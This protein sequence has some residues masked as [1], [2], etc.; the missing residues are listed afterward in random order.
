[1]ASLPVEASFSNNEMNPAAMEVRIA[2]SFADIAKI[3]E[4]WAA[5]K[6][7]RDC[8]IDFCLSFIWSAQEFVRPHIIV[9]YRYG[10]AD[11]ILIGRVERVRMQS[12]IGY[13]RLPSASAFLLNFAHGG[14]LGEPSAENSAEFIKSIICTLKEGD[15]DVALVDRSTVGSPMYEKART[16]PGFLSRDRLTHPEPHVVMTL[17]ANMDEI[18]AGFSSGLRAEVR[19]K[20][21]MIVADFGDRVKIQCY[22]DY[23]DLE[24]AV[25]QIEEVAKRTYQRALGVGFEDSPRMQQ[26]LDLCARKQ[27]LRIY[28]LTLDGKPRAFWVGTVYERVFY[29]DYNGYDPNFR[30]YSLGTFLLISMIEDFCKER[31]NA[32]DFGFG[33]AEYKSRF[34]N[35]R[36]V[37]AS[38]YIFSPTPKGFMLNAGRTV[39]GAMD[40]ALRGILER[41]D[42]L[43]KLKRFWRS[44]LAGKRIAE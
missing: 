21:K 31:I 24:S 34:S 2:Q 29:S 25:P 20:K 12:K 44:R 4:I 26:R 42:L 18:F 37:K 6:G 32:I 10:R 17:G 7:H 19:R 11:A 38:V 43:P 15:V 9:L 8:D 5:S 13:L 22:R 35:C 16:M 36:V 27:W 3:R 33:E 41:T 1:M 40:A 14:F 39:T 23:T 30:D 28:V